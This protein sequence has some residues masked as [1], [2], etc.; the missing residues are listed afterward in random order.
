MCASYSLMESSQ[1]V[2][3]EGRQER[4]GR[5]GEI[6]SQTEGQVVGWMTGNVAE[7]IKNKVTLICVSLALPV[8]SHSLPFA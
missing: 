5:K 2:W 8:K 3:K 4:F 6:N 7:N 1:E